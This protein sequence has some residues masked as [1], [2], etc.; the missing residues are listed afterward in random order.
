[1]ALGDSNIAVPVAAA[2]PGPPLP[3][4]TLTST[5][6]AA[7]P[8]PSPVAAGSVPTIIT[9][10]AVEELAN[11]NHVSWDEARAQ[12]ETA[13]GIT[14]QTTPTP[15]TPPTA[16]SKATPP[17]ASRV[18]AAPTKG[19]PATPTTVVRA[20]PPAPTRTPAPAVV[21]GFRDGTYSGSG[22][23]RRGDIQVSLSVQNGRVASVNI[24]SATTQ[25]PTRLIAGLPGEVIARQSAQVDT[26]SGATFSSLAFRGAVQQALQRAQA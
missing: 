11:A 8:A 22:T 18:V 9:D 23:S 12:M 10:Q 20:A 15:E 1:V 2:P 19:A 26:I 17:P 13:A 4:P 25:Y 24:T 7:T 6:E 3:V 14:H 16:V 5:A 21:A